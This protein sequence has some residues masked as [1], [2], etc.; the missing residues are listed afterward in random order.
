MK[1]STFLSAATRLAGLL[2]NRDRKLSNS[3]A[4]VFGRDGSF[5]AAAKTLFNYEE[6]KR[7]F[8]VRLRCKA[9]AAAR[10]SAAAAFDSTRRPDD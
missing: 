1:K 4:G 3:M 9:H 5:F 7:S 10:D 2:Q 6:E 8:L